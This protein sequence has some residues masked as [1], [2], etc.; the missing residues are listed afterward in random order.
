MARRLKPVKRTILPDVR[1]NNL[2][3][4]MIINRIMLDGKKSTITSSVYDAFDLIKAKTG[5]E[6][7]E[8]FETALRNVS[9]MMEV[10]PR[11]VGGATYQVPM[12]VAP[13]RRLT[14]AMRWLITASRARSG[15]SYSEKFAAELMDASENQGAAIRRKEEVHKMAE[16]NRAFSH[17]RI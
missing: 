7:V 2:H 6:G 5:K 16:A 1:F 11:R 12:E 10:R 4:Q 3:V 14:L 13:D 8:V 9:P 15:K 17:F